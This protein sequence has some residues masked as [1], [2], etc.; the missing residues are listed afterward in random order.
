[1]PAW[2]SFARFVAGRPV[3]VLITALAVRYF[4]VIDRWQA[5]VGAQA[6]AE[7]DALQARIR[8]H[9]LFNSMNMIASLLRRDPEVAERAVLDLSDLFRAALGAG[10]GTSTLAE[11]VRLVE[12]YLAIDNCDW[13]RGCGWMVQPEPLRGPC[14]CRACVQPWWGNAC[15]TAVPAAAAPPCAEWSRR[16]RAAG[17]VRK[18]RC[19]P[20]TGVHG[21]GHAKRRSAT[22]SVRL[23]RGATPGLNDGNMT[24][25]SDSRDAGEGG[26]DAMKVVIATTIRWRE[27]ACG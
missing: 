3:V 13:E 2:P 8:P 10:E 27:S 6:R 24:A 18:P 9:F 26:G 20:T 1:M 21:A 15:C 7:V 14:R 16:R 5:Q 4:H 17:A 11:E 25:S 12:Q 19:R 23:G 22:A